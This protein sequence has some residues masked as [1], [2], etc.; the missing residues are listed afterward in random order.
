MSRG[1]TLLELL[2]VL[3]VMAIAAGV[4]ALGWR[5]GRTTPAA[6]VMAELE[7]ARDRAVRGGRVVRWEGPAGSVWFW[8][9]GSATPARLPVEGVVVVVEPLTG[10]VRAER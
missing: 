9:D 6:A 3:V 5:A 1:V 2:L 8:P 4:T 10:V 7:A